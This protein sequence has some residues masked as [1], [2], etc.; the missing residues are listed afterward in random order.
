MTFQDAIE[1][2]NNIKIINACQLKKTQALEKEEILEKYKL[3]E[4]NDGKKNS[5]KKSLQYSISHQKDKHKELE[6]VCNLRNFKTIAQTDEDEDELS[7]KLKKAKVARESDKVSEGSMLRVLLNKNF[8][9]RIF[10]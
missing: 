4:L 2:R 5:A 10:K 1:S 9:G 8:R 3:L 6:Y 7:K